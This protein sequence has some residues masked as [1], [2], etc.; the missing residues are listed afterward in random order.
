VCFVI[1]EVNE[2][3]TNLADQLILAK[4]RLF[5]DQ[6]LQIIVMWISLGTG[7]Q[8]ELEGLSPED[9]VSALRVVAAGVEGQSGGGAHLILAFDHQIARV[10]RKTTSLADET[11][12]MPHETNL[13]TGL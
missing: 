6:R 12:Q 7:L 1:D 2:R 10:A 8:G 5:E 11:A 4:A 13:F 9:A 3:N